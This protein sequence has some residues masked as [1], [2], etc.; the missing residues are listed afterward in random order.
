[1][2]EAWFLRRRRELGH[3][4]C[5]LLLP[6]TQLMYYGL[7]LLD[8]ILCSSGCLAFNHNLSL[9][10]F[11]ACS[12]LNSLCS[13]QDRPLLVCCKTFPK[14]LHPSNSLT[15]ASSVIKGL[16]NFFEALNSAS[17]RNVRTY[18]LEF[19]I[20]FTI[21]IEKL[22]LVHAS[23]WSAKNYFPITSGV[24]DSSQLFPYSAH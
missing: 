15:V 14:I 11:W 4:Q 7:R 23:L 12:K 6:E 21:F 8:V 1:M 10:W 19:P 24:C 20:T 16:L 13:E 9:W 2:L 5:G 17:L 22:S 18:S 3:C